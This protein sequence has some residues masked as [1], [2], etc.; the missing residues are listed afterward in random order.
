[1]FRFIITTTFFLGLLGTRIDRDVLQCS[2]INNSYTIVSVRNKN[3]NILLIPDSIKKKGGSLEIKYIS[4]NAFKNYSNLKEIILSDKIV[5]IGC[6]AFDGCSSLNQIVIPYSVESIEDYAFSGCSSLKDVYVSWLEPDSIETG[7][8]PFGLDSHLKTLHVPQGTI[9]KYTEVGYPWVNFGLITD[10]ID[11]LISSFVCDDFICTIT[12][13]NKVSLVYRGNDENVS[14]PSEVTSQ[15]LDS[16]YTVISIGNYAFLNNC[17]LNAVCLPINLEAIEENAFEGCKKLFDIN[18]PKGLKRIA[19]HAFQDCTNL[20]EINLPESLDAIGDAAF[21][22]CDSII[23][24]QI[25]KSVSYIGSYAFTCNT[26]KVYWQEPDS[27][28]IRWSSFFGKPGE[29]IVPQGTLSKYENKLKELYNGT[30]F[31]IGIIRDES[32]FSER[33]FVNN[34]LSYEVIEGSNYVNLFSCNK[35]PNRK[36]LVVDS[37]VKSENT[38][39]KYIVNSIVGDFSN[40][41]DIKEITINDGISMIGMETFRTCKELECVFLPESLDSIGYWAFIGC[42]KLKHIYIYSCIPQFINTGIFPDKK[43][44]IHVRKKYKH[45]YESYDFSHKYKVVYDL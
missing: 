31:G 33:Y 18:F 21:F 26:Y 14:V 3:K 6:N 32:S 8:H 28:N 22:G 39:F 23:L 44:T 37:F 45:I 30:S 19:S 42:R 27:I 11:S 10:G 36:S 20:I 41:H 12:G 35:D 9:S 13:V 16:T 17:R 43:I 29:L 4:N 24:V 5:D 1:M 40:L 34:G 38:G 15:D 2:I 7:I 25:P